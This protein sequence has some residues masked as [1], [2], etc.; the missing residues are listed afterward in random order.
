MLMLNGRYSSTGFG[1]DAVGRIRAATRA[2]DREVI[3]R[4]IIRSPARRSDR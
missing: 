1:G 4:V 3:E 2:L